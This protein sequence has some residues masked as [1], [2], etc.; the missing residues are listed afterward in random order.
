MTVRAGSSWRRPISKSTGSWP[1]VTLMT[2]VPNFGSTAL[3][4]TTRIVIVP[5]TEGTSRVWPTYFA[6]RLSFGWTARAVSPSL[7]SG[8][9][10]PRVSGPYLM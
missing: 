4:A 6:Y 1:G 2:P 9:T 7:V 5:S 3:S 8:R 10:V